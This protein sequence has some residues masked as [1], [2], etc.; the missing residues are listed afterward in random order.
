ML[1]SVIIPVFNEDKTIS[2]VVR[3]VKRVDVTKEIIVVDDGS[4]DKTQEILRG[5]AEEIILVR[6]KCNRGKGAAI[7][8]GLEKVSGDIVIIQ[9]ADL[10]LN[11]EEYPVLLTPIIKRETGIV[12]GSRFLN[13]KS[14]LT[15]NYLAN[16][17]LTFLTNLLFFS[18]L[19]DMETCYKVFRSELFNDLKI[20]SDRFDIEPEITA[21]VLKRGWR[22]KEVPVSYQARRYVSGK[23]IGFRDGIMAIWTLLKY[24]IVE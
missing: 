14:S 3:R 21:K 17:F 15:L 19:T 7:R 6:H 20:K 5:L 9:D 11:P 2:E 22:I 1:L 4:C 23:K 18:R 10:E 24:R 13:R 8:S 16:Q 12:Y